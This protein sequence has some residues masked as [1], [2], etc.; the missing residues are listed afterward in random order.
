MKRSRFT[1]TQIIKHLKAHE[2]GRAAKDICREIGI[3]EA[4]FYKWRQKYGG[5]EAKE[6]KRL[7]ELEEE[8][9]RLKKQLFG[10]RSQR[11]MTEENQL[12]FPEMDLPSEE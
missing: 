3:S 7:K 12:E 4:T 9:Q 1:E 6:L 2:A 8:N 5:M 11:L 10:K